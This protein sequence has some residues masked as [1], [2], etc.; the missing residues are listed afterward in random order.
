MNLL[1]I[2][3][4]IEMINGI[5]SGINW[6]HLNFNQIFS[7]TNPLE[8]KKILSENTIEIVLCDIEMPDCSGLD[9]I[10]WVKENYPSTLCVILTCHEN[11]SYA[12]RAISLGCE[13]YILKPILYDELEALL[14]TLIQN[15][16]RIDETE[17]Y[18]EIGREWI[19]RLHSTF[20]ENTL[21]K[22]EMV[23]TVKEYINT[24]LKAELKTDDLAALVHISADY[25]FRIF[26]QIEHCTL[27]EYILN[28]R[29]YLAAQLLKE[30]NL[31]V[32]RV[33]FE[34]GYNNFSYFTKLF[35]KQYGV[36]PREYRQ[37]NVSPKT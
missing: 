16:L 13:E 17:K 6:Q 24:H 30:C 1:L 12:Q 10:A 14:K 35:K 29:M 7:C 36:T 9:L 15:K 34:C 20:K 25:L 18:S 26:R 5:K 2:D 33:A 23:I 31:S 22:E 37:Q 4:E 28:K 27:G 3:D 21:S 32:S 11:F 8:A 19:E